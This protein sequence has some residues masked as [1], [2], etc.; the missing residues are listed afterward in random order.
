VRV[1]ASPRTAA[2]RA[3][4]PDAACID[5]VDLAR[6]AAEE[7]A[8]A[9]AVGEH[10]DAYAEAERVATHLFACLD[11]GYR[12]WRWAV[13]VARAS[14]GRTV[15]VDEVVLLPGP[16]SLL[17]PP[18]VPWSERVR[19]GDLGPGDVLPTPA[20]DPRL[21]AGYS[22]EDDLEGL[23]GP[24]PLSPGQWEI[25]LGRPRVLSE[26]GRV[27]AADRWIEGDHGPRS[28]MAEAA[29]ARCSTCGF[30]VTI[31]GAMGQAFGLCA[32]QMSPSDG[33]VVALDHGC[34]AHSDAD[35]EAMPPPAEAVHDNL[36]YDLLD[37]GHS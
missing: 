1:T 14:R 29:P 2:K 15:T 36:G 4:K 34:G 23:A 24:S 13:T 21:V 9:G 11:P 3:A 8:P 37:L 18:W 12:G 35:A 17:A 10:L 31:G 5:A 27:E 33:H 26:L 28:P 19:P 6:A 32:N 16:D 30:L 20:D 7:D 25:G 22:G